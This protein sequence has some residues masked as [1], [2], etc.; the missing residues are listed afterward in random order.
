MSSV[1]IINCAALSS[2]SSLCV[3][4]LKCQELRQMVSILRG[5]S[6][7]VLQHLSGILKGLSH[8]SIDVRLS[9][10]GR[11]RHALYHNQT[12]VHHLTT[13]SDNVHP[14]VS[15]LF[16]ALLGRGKHC[17]TIVSIAELVHS[18]SPITAVKRKE[19]H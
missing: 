16:S 18:F 2:S 10:L 13:A 6:E 8:E 14:T 19:S 9:A 5:T 11:L 4:T 12:A 17:Q 3:L 1:C 7:E 15:E